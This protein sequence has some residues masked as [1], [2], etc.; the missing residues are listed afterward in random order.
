MRAP[1]RSSG[2]GAGERGGDAGG[3]RALHAGA[4]LAAQEAAR[5]REPVGTSSDVVAVVE[6]LRAVLGRDDHRRGTAV[7]LHAQVLELAQELAAADDVGADDRAERAPALRVEGELARP[8]AARA[9]TGA[10][11]RRRGSRR[12]RSGRKRRSS[13]PQLHLEAERAAA[14]ACRGRGRP[15]GRAGC[16]RSRIGRR[17]TCSTETP[18]TAPRFCLPGLPSKSGQAREALLA[19]RAGRSG[20][21]RSGRSPGPRGSARSAGA[22]GR[23]GRRPGRRAGPAPR[24]ARRAWPAGRAQRPRRRSRRTARARA[25]RASRRRRARGPGRRSRRPR[26]P[27]APARRARGCARSCAPRLR[28]RRARRPGSPSPC[29]R[30]ARARRRAARAP[31]RCARPCTAARSS[32]PSPIGSAASSYARPAMLLRD[33]ELA[34]HALHRREHALVV[35]AAAA[36]LV[37]DHATRSCR[38]VSRHARARARTPAARRR[39]DRARAAATSVIVARRSAE[40]DG[41]HRHLGVA[42]DERAVAAA[43]RVVPARRGRRTPSPARPRRAPRPRSGSAARPRHGR[44]PS[45][46]VDE[47]RPDAR[48]RR[49][50]GARRR[51]RPR[52]RARPRRRASPSRRSASSRASWRPRR[53]VDHPGAVRGGDD[54]VVDGRERG[55]QLRRPRSTCV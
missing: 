25:G 31:R 14:F 50:R 18:R 37:L 43:A 53:S 10:R 35:D 45:G 36:Q 6:R 29:R 55:L 13:S 41:Q 4:S 20:T 51:R 40:P 27:R 42:G 22:A 26:A 11:S 1:K 9:A 19:Q 52:G 12:R 30:R 7:G 16:P 38:S 33:E 49:R 8:R 24:A 54:D 5:T 39:S 15:A 46:Y 32:G 23:G 2:A 3:G 17:R 21:A 47:R 28:A 44:A 34:R 48:P